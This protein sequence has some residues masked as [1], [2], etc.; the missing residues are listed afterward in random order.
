M[1]IFAKDNKDK[2]G[3]VRERPRHSNNKHHTN[4]LSHRR[5][6]E[7]SIKRLAESADPST[8][9]PHPTHAHSTA[10]SYFFMKHF[11]MK[12]QFICWDNESEFLDCI[13][14]SSL[15]EMT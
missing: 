11:P 6:D 15:Y 1:Y 3:K 4:A 14:N 5:Q 9:P 13:Y 8:H 7:E 10:L 2:D 12:I